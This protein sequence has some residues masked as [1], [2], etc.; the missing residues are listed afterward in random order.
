[1]DGDELAAIRAKRMAEMKASQ[2]G[3]AGGMSGM[4]VSKK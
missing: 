3:G 4:G 1:M 2:G